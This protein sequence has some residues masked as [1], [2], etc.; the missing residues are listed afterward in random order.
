[1]PA[2]V[3]AGRI[4]SSTGPHHARRPRRHPATVAGV[5]PGR[6]CCGHP[7]RAAY[8]RT[9]RTVGDL[10]TPG[11][12]RH[13]RRLLYRARDVYG[14]AGALMCLDR[15]AAPC[16]WFEQ[17]NRIERCPTWSTRRPPIASEVPPS[18]DALA[19]NA[20]P[21]VIFLQL[22]PPVPRRRPVRSA[23]S[24][25]WLT[26]LANCPDAAAGWAERARHVGGGC[27]GRTGVGVPGWRAQSGLHG[28]R[29]TQAPNSPPT[30]SNRRACWRTV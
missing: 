24:T 9:E 14:A 7:E 20:E 25:N 21:L 10:A 6:C 27:P 5:R 18:G 3:P 4:A 17:P 29:W 16:R 15:L 11:A 12:L 22:K 26:S 30:P 8:H 1:M 23:A 19:Q 2:R 28:S 13:G